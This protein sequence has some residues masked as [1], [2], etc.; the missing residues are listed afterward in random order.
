MT[1]VVKSAFAAP[2]AI[3]ARLRDAIDLE[4]RN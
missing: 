2:P 3:I 1:E 4:N